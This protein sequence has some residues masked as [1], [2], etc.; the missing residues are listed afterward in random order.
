MRDPLFQLCCNDASIAIKPVFE[1]FQSVVITS[2]TLSPLDM[3]KK[4]L[5][6]EPVVV[7][8]FQMS[9][10]RDVIRPLVVTRGADQ[11]VLSSKY[12]TRSEPATIRNYGKLLLE[13]ARAVPDGVVAFFTS[14]MYMQEIVREWHNIG[15]LKQVLQHKLV[16]IET[17]DVLETTLALENFKRACDCGRGAVFLSVARGKVAEGVDFDRHYGRAVLLLG[18]PFQYTLGRVLRARLEYLRDTCGIN[19]ADFLTFDAIRQAAQCAGRVIR[20][21]SDY[22]L[23]IFADSRYNKQ[24]KKSKLPQ[25]IQQFMSDALSNL[26]TDVAMASARQFL[27]EMA[28][29]A[30]Q[31]KNVSLT[32]SELTRH[33]IY[34]SRV[35]TAG[36]DQRSAL[37]EPSRARVVSALPAAAAAVVPMEMG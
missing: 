5:S 25:W 1:R 30:P 14:Y 34:V 12:D 37:P 22:G 6:V 28:Q 10:A 33:P 4:I 21:K 3:Y 16:F 31:H 19:E 11:A 2:G 26:S 8:S 7:Q 20:G 24:D 36:I 13:C 15:V 32:E 17:T 29:P 23:V 18:V 27:R 35:S 9:F